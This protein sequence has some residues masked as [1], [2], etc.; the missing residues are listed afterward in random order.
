MSELLTA[1]AALEA[2]ITASAPPRIDVLAHAF[3]AQR[4]WSADSSPFK[5]SFCTRRAA[6]SYSV[7]LE[8]VNDSF[9]YPRAHYLFLM[10]VRA[11]AKRDFWNDVLKDIDRRFSLDMDF[12]ETELIARM[13][14]GAMIY[15]GGADSSSQ[16]WRKM[17]AGKYRKVH[18]DEA[19]A[20]VHADLGQLVYEAFKPAVADYRGTIGLSGTPGVVNKGLFFDVT[21][22]RESGWS[23]HRW[24]T[25]DNP[26]MAEK[27]AAEIA[28]LKERKPGVERTP[29]FRRNYLA[30]WVIEDTALVYRYAAGRNDF[31]ELP[32]YTKGQWRYLLGV[33]LGHT[34]ATSF[35]VV[36][37]HDH[38]PNLYV[39]LSRK[40]PGLDFTGVALQA[41]AL[42]R[43]FNFEQ[44]IVDGANKQGVEEMRKR[45]GCPWKAAEKTAKADYIE[46]MNAEFLAGTVKLG[47]DCDPL[48][49]EYTNLVWE[50]PEAVKRV[51]HPACDNHCADGALYPWRY[52]YSYL[53]ERLVQKPLQGSVE[54]LAEEED[55]IEAAMEERVREEI[56]AREDEAWSQ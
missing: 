43:K 5:A 25:S 54:A 32:T 52:A 13:P 51:E 49:E 4:R 37:Y 14:N 38:D 27:I 15:V 30:E 10:T 22:G 31:T 18:I 45:H 28:Q 41:K 42:D 20:F 9:D 40:E 26:F 34:D 29:W 46:L 53:S 56:A 16:E 1:A 50:D 7:G 24:R 11:Q 3:E 35:Q 55:A 36:A 17:I 33:D 23:V 12:N 6:K 39:V 44:W 47:P 8:F 21:Q 48:R 19:Q 2:K